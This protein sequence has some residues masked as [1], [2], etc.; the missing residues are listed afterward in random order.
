M[1]AVQGLR[2]AASVWDK[3]QTASTSASAGQLSEMLG[4]MKA[5]GGPNDSASSNDEDAVTIQR[6]QSDGSILILTMK[7]GEVV[8]ES[9]IRAPQPMKGAAPIEGA[10]ANAPENAQAALL[11]RFNDT[12]TSITAGA[13]F[14]AGV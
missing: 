4:R 3:T 10:L 11:D 1:S 13:L 6:Y 9:K 14:S 8:S 5:G 2:G 7:D 12:S